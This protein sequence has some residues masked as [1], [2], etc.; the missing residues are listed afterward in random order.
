MPM[1]RFKL[2]LNQARMPMVPSWSPRAAL[3][4]QLDVIQKSTSQAF[5]GAVE[6]ADFNAPQILYG[7]NFVPWTQGIKSV[8]YSQ[9]V[10]GITDH[11]D[12]DQIFPLRDEEENQV[13]FSPANGANYIVGP[14]G[15]W[16]ANPPL[17][18][19]WAGETPPLFLSTASINNLETARVTPAYVDGKT[20][21]A[22]SG[23]GLSTTNG[24]ATLDKDGSIYLWNPTT[25]Q[26]ER[27]NPQGTAGL[28]Q[29][30]DIPIGEIGGIASSNGYL[31]VWSGLAV[32]WAAFNGEAFDFTIY[33]N[34]AITGS[35]SQIPE[36]V[37]GPITAIRAVSGGFIIFTSRNCVA[38]YYN[39]NNFASPWIFKGISNGGGLEDL[40]LSTRE[41]SKGSIFAYTTGGV[42]Q[43]TLNAAE[44]FAPD[45]T[46][47][48]G[49][50]SLERFN[51]ST[52]T[53]TQGRSSSEF[54]VK[55]TYVG[56]RFLVV[57]YGFIPGTY[58][59]ALIFDTAL[60][61]WGKLRLAHR[62]AFIYSGTVETVKLTYGML[63]DVTYHEM[64]DIPYNET[65]T[66]TSGLTYPRQS[67]AFLLK[68]GTI[69]LAVMDFRDKE[70]DSESFVV[71]GKVQLS[72]SSNVTLH[73]VEVEGLLADGEEFLRAVHM[74]NGV[75]IAGYEEGFVREQSSRFTEFGID[76]LT[77]KTFAL[78]VK[79]T[80]ELSTMIVHA[81]PES[82]TY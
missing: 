65:T 68:D 61:R 81:S 79:G 33:A 72:R 43:I 1:Q 16:I 42:Q 78:V 53:F 54:F 29:N 44:S 27:Q 7:E 58:S 11:T 6:N 62:D 14:S 77:G 4:P 2:A 80:Y 64:A 10:P 76:M 41:T 63:I 19:Q 45:V 36:D 30:L 31:L 60:Q 17:G 46:D 70:D 18:Q 56:S 75:D 9:V 37:E 66:Q 13:L 51:L 5:F 52:M 74:P 15:V 34:G 50:R 28:I 71:L 23:I 40:E 48:L 38:A 24:G 55:M 82:S 59:F 12:F 57:S 21:I 47:F 67:L 8:S 69:K 35:G 73:C 49:S 3:I 25:L 32:H 39:A 20:F 26:F 22:Y